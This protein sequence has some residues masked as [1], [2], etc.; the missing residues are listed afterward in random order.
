MRD[1]KVMVTALCINGVQCINQ[2]N[3][4]SEFF[5]TSKTTYTSAKEEAALKFARF[6]ATLEKPFQIKWSEWKRNT[7]A[8]KDSWKLVGDFSL[9][10]KDDGDT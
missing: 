2:I 10:V 1:Y 8:Q 3:D 4:V 7:Y 9:E 5:G 6:M